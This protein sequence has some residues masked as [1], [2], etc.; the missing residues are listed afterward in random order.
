ME[1]R[2]IQTLPETVT[3]ACTLPFSTSSAS[4]TS[5][6]LR[7]RAASTGVA[8]GTSR[9]QAGQGTVVGGSAGE[10]IRTRR[11]RTVLV[12]TIRG[13]AVSHDIIPAPDVLVL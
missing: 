5:P 10:L 6:V 7:R 9:A 4:S 3:I 2:Q 8:P 1:S 13:I 12:V 11:R